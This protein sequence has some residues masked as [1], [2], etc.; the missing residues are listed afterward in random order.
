VLQGLAESIGGPDVAHV[1]LSE[2]GK[3]ASRFLAMVSAAVY[4]LRWPASGGRGQEG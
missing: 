4:L 1:T 2:I 3:S